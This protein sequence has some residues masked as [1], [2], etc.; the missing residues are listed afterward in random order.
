M[1]AAAPKT[2]LRRTAMYAGLAAVLSLGLVGAA[3][4][5]QR[6]PDAK[7]QPVMAQSPVIMPD[8]RQM[9][10]QKYEVT[11]AE[12]NACHDAGA[13]TLAL[14]APSGKTDVTTPATGLSFVDVGQYL[15]WINRTARHDFRLPTLAEWEYMA[16]EVLPE[17]PDPIFT[18]PD[19]TWASAYLTTPQTKR[20]LRAQG[21]FKTTSQG[22]VDLDG[23]VWEWTSEC[24]AGA[25][26]GSI[27]PDRCPAFFV[28]GEH[29]AAI[30]FLE[31]DPARGGCA[32]GAPPAHLGMRLISD[33][34]S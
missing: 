19:L 17:E 34:D 1:A 4:M 24:Y 32:V 13:C 14:R 16:A 21:A 5:L 30:S 12:W 2:T 18:S 26:E 9:F 29:I 11:I 7:N 15:T 28:G 31:R 25:A 10:V 27:S 8:G 6:G 23:S 20:T 22:I 3:Q 33:Y